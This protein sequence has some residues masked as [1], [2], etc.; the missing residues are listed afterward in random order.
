M[1]LSFS[2][3][4]YLSLFQD[5]DL[6][7]FLFQDFL[8][9]LSGLGFLARSGRGPSVVSIAEP[10]TREHPGGGARLENTCGRRDGRIGSCL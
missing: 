1:G 7:R 3:V 6:P 2:Q 5:V 4:W 9:F 8:M 10:N